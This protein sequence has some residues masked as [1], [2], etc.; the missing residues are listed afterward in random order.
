MAKHYLFIFLLTF[1]SS[2]ALWA[3]KDPAAIQQLEDV[4]TEIKNLSEHVSTDKAS[5]AELFQQLKQQSRAVS[6][7]N[8]TLLELK[9][10][11]QRQSVELVQLE[12]RQQ[13]EQRSH[14][15]EL[16]A[17]T[18]Q[19]R[20]AYNTSQPNFVKVLLNQQDPASF[21]RSSIYFHYFNQA[22]QQQLT[23]ISA[24]LQNLTE[25][26]KSL[27]AAQKKQQRLYNQQQ[28]KQQAL[29]QQTQQR[30]ATLAALDKKIASQDS[31]LTLL[32][33]QEQSLQALLHS[34]NK[35]KAN[36]SSNSSHKAFAKRAGSLTWPVKGKVLARYGSTRKLGKLK[37]QGIMI[38]SASGKDVVASAPGRIVFSDWLRGFGLLMII[39][40]GDQYMTLYGNNETLLKQVGDNV[41]SGEL[42]AQSGDKGIRQYAG[43]YF[44]L[45][46]KGNPRNPLKW[47]SKKS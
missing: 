40:H 1:S 22:R 7:L 25:D 31:R 33:E 8:K 21:R 43:L 5:Q 38:A 28:Q 23:D 14:D 24:I 37:W 30:Q 29:Q 39:D 20:A 35:P 16:T 42:I 18:E 19:I 17:L 46:H 36:T 9:Q 47:L 13:Q 3:A 26:Q 11:I 15:F 27:L 32:K 6:T 45:R 12:K 44:E 34:L 10:K 2:T 4:K 41:V